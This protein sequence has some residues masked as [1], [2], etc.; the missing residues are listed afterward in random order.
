[1]SARDAL[2]SASERL[3]VDSGNEPVFAEPWQASAFAMS[4]HLH[5]RGLFTWREW[6]SALSEHLKHQGA[7]DDGSDY[8][9]AWLAAL[10]SLIKTKGIAMQSSLD[11]LADR[12]KR[13][14][15]ATP[16]GKPILLENDPEAG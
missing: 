1:M 9:R 3:P 13:A 12:W 10:E 6:A 2:I 16:H 4:V 14:A 7:G 15:E 8:Y 11:D 5:E